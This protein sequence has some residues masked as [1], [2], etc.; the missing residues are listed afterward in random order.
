MPLVWLTNE[1]TNR[2]TVYHTRADCYHLNR[3]GSGNEIE[4]T[5]RG[6]EASGLRECQNCEK[7]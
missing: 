7:L 2:Q 5:K 3:V 4:A 1:G 6:A